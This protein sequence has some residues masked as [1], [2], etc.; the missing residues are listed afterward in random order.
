MCVPEERCSGQGVWLS[1][2]DVE[3]VHDQRGVAGVF[4]DGKRRLGGVGNRQE[5]RDRNASVGKTTSVTLGG[6]RC[7]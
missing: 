6:H 7:A 4:N 5:G 3:T 2:T 1:D